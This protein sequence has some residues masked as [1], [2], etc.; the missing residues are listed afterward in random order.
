MKLFHVETKYEGEIKLPEMLLEQLP[1]KVMLAGTIQFREQIGDIRKQIEATGRKVEL[2]RG[3]HDAA[4][5]QMLGCDIFE[6]GKDISAFLY[7]GDGMFHPTAFLYENQKIVFYYN[8]FTCEVIKLT[9]NDMK[10]INNKRKIRC[11][12]YFR[13]CAFG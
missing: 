7:V 3:V 9:Q 12:K 8:P 2:F 10:K 13:I 1:G 5:G 11:Y 6:I 4:S